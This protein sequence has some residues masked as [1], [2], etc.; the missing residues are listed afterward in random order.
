MRKKTCQFL[1]NTSGKV[2]AAAAAQLGREKEGVRPMMAD[3]KSCVVPRERC[4]FGVRLR[5][6]TCRGRA[7]VVTTTSRKGSKQVLKEGVF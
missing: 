7:E 2:A 4:G 6:S 1:G 5:P 3:K